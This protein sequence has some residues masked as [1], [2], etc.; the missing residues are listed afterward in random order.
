MA[1]EYR[2]LTTFITPWGRYQY[3]MA[4]Q[5]S[6][7]SG[8]GYSRRYDEVIADVDRKTKCVDDTAHWDDDLS[9][10]WW[11]MLDFLEL[12]GR[13]G[14]VLNFDKFQFAQREISFAGFRVT[15]SEVQPLDKY[16]RAISEFP[17]PK[18]TVDIRSWFGL[19]HQVSHYNQLTEMMSPFKPFL[20]PKTKFEWNAELDR[21]FEASKIEIINAIKNGVEIFDPTKLTCLRP[22]WSKQGI[23]Y[24]L[25]QKHL[26]V[27]PQ[28]QD[29][30]SMAGRLP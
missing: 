4:P 18:R 30:V 10:H 9:V 7:A 19:V 13:N 14:I 2:H 26:I 29:A 11:R 17:T 20:S 28:S 24:F 16:I 6:L 23:G 1:E 3:R 21:V 22:D 8:D 15:E 25:S 27:N 5:G 12:C